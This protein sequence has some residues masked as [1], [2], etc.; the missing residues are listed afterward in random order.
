MVLQ[1]RNRVLHLELG[2]CMLESLMPARLH[3][4]R[5]DMFLDLQ[6]GL[7]RSI[8]NVG[9]SSVGFE[10]NDKFALNNVRRLAFALVFLRCGLALL[11]RRG[12]FGWFCRLCV[13]RHGETS[14]RH[15]AK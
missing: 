5:M 8:S 10:L 1:N 14:K 11:I 7:R 15:G 9:V 4:R 6:L 13:C 3:R 12:C 2:R